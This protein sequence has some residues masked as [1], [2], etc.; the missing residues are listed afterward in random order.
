MA[1][2]LKTICVNGED[3]EDHRLATVGV[4]AAW[5]GRGMMPQLYIEKDGECLSFSPPF[6]IV[7]FFCFVN[8]V[9]LSLVCRPLKDP[10]L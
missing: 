9:S 3:W 8:Y 2:A 6:R 1:Q 10:Y 4:S 5:R 7:V